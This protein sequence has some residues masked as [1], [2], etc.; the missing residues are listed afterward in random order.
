MEN[1]EAK[2][3]IDYDRQVAMFGKERADTVLQF[4]M[5]GANGYR[6]KPTKEQIINFALEA[7]TTYDELVVTAENKKYFKADCGTKWLT[8]DELFDECV[9]KF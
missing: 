8:I 9:G 1:E 7:V 4:F 6:Q 2:T 3:I 5:L